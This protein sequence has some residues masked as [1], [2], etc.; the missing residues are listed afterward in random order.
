MAER[1]VQ[2]HVHVLERERRKEGGNHPIIDE[3][4]VESC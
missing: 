3:D 2:S 4:P 1:K